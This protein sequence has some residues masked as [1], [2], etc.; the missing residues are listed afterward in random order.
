MLTASHAS[1][2]SNTYCEVFVLSV[3]WIVLSMRVLED[4]VKKV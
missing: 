2:T 3:V 4:T 1:Y